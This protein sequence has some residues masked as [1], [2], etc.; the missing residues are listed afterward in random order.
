MKPQ[1]L[2]NL[3]TLCL[4][5]YLLMRQDIM[6]GEGKQNINLCNLLVTTLCDGPDGVMLQ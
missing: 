5:F 2:R 1:M 4:T 3:I 6:Y